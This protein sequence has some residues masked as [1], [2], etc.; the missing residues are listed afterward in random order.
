[1]SKIVLNR[2]EIAIDKYLSPSQSA[3]RKYRSTSDIVWSYRWILAKVQ[4]YE[5]LTVYVTCQVPL[6]QYTGIK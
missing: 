1:M 6:T 2:A 5:D 3:Y 4:E